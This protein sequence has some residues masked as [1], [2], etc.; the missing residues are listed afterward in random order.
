[1]P[2]YITPTCIPYVAPGAQFPLSTQQ[3]RVGAAR[4]GAECASYGAVILGAQSWARQGSAVQ[5]SAAPAALNCFNGC[6]IS[7]EDQTKK[8][9][10]L[11]SVV[12]F[13][14]THSGKF[15]LW[16][17]TAMQCLEGEI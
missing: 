4:G 14:W 11:P 12:L 10:L 8:S 9:F 1:M 13:T 3:E 5:G 17:T 16:D 15:P 2:H 7:S 6:D